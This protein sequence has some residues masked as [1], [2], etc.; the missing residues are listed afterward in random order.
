MRLY[1]TYY[2][3]HHDRKSNTLGQS[4][5]QRVYRRTRTC[6]DKKV[7]TEDNDMTKTMR[8]HTREKTTASFNEKKRY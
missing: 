4:R 1:T 8:E 2:L 6:S 7:T 3:R 5:N